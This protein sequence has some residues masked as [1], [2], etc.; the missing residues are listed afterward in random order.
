MLFQ[1]NNQI[2]SNSILN[3][4]CS[5][6]TLENRGAAFQ[7][8]G[9]AVTISCK[10]LMDVTVICVLSLCY[11]ALSVSHSPCMKEVYS[12]RLFLSPI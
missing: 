5:V 4:N 7:I 11:K 10:P 3:N 2:L 12:N 1:V 6:I 8:W 9:S